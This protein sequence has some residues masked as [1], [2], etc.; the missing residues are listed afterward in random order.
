MRRPVTQPFRKVRI[1][2]A[3]TMGGTKEDNVCTRVNA[4]STT[5]PIGRLMFQRRSRFDSLCRWEI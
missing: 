3:V 5:T 1:T 4:L 2:A